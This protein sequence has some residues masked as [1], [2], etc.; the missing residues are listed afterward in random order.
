MSDEPTL[1]CIV[2]PAE[3]KRFGK[4]ARKKA[5]TEWCKLA[6]KTLPERDSLVD[7]DILTLLNF[8]PHRLAQAESGKLSQVS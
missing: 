5:C 6:S 3:R 4:E 1:L 7:V 8:I 2:L